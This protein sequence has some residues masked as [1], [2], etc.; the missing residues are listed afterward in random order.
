MRTFPLIPLALLLAGGCGV[1]NPSPEQNAT[2]S[3]REHARR[4]GERI[5]TSRVLPA[6]DV[7]HLAADIEGV[8]V[9]RVTGTSTA[10]G[11]GVGVVIR[12]SGTAPRDSWDSSE[13]TVIR[14]FELRV[15]VWTERG[16]T[17]SD[18]DCPPGR[19]LTFKPW[20]ETPKIPFERLRRAL[21]H[22]PRGGT[23]DEPK[24]RE[25]VASLHLD[26]AI[27][28]EIK[29]EDGVVGVSLTAKPYLHDALDCVLARVAP[30]GTDVRTPARM[31]RMPGEGG[32][33]V[34]NAIHP[35]SP[36]H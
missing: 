3:A 24:V 9:M 35:M 2:D 31:Q 32:C 22:V 27:H 33:D 1:V 26:P 11:D 23:V 29:A 10:R 36:P 18:V 14:C 20:P 7:G 4:V 16:A 6:R 8:D 5:Y 34:A 13:V 21:P 28:T 15:S 19:P 25:A 30:G 17:P 12:V